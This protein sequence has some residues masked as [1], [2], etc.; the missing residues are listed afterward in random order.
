M[1]GHGPGNGPG[2]GH[3]HGPEAKN[4][5]TGPGKNSKY[6]SLQK[7]KIRVKPLLNIV[8]IVE[9]SLLNIVVVKQ[10]LCFSYKFFDF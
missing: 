2:H 6:K 10:K 1:D 5:N 7:F 4:Q 3:G 9:E 8:C